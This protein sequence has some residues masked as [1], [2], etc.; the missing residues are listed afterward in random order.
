M[1]K[2]EV[3]DKYFNQPAVTHF[4]W[5]KHISNIR[6]CKY[7]KE[8]WLENG[9][10][11]RQYGHSPFEETWEEFYR[12]IK[13]YFKFKKKADLENNLKKFDW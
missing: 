7:L 4:L 9:I 12:A 5:F 1:T 11:L 8:F 13:K 2:E 10:L 3:I 6:T